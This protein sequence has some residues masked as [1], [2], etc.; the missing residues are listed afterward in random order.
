MNMSFHAMRTTLAL[1]MT[2]AQLPSAFAQDDQNSVTSEDA[3]ALFQEKMAP[4]LLHP[5]C[6]NCH[7]QGDAPRQGDTRRVHRQ[8]I[9]RGKDDHGHVALRCS[10]CHGS[11]N[12]AGGFVPGAPGW[13]LAPKEM[14]W[15]GLTAGGVCRAMLD[16]KRNHGKSLAETVHHLKNDKLVAW[17]WAPGTRS[18]VPIPKD[19]FDA[20]V[21]MWASAGAPCPP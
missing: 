11:A 13:A 15:E 8:N 5:R 12:R 2:V 4:V 9:M 3:L 17:G 19:E 21:E 14:A 16:P 10:A 1:T 6:V 20:A 18:A 7:P